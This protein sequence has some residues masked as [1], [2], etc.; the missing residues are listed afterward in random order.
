MFY[1][2]PKREEEEIKKIEKKYKLTKDEIMQIKK[3]FVEYEFSQILNIDI[4]FNIY[5]KISLYLI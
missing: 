3:W 1:I 5:F 4:V 2:P